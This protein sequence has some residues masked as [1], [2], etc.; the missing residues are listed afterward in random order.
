MRDSET[1]GFELHRFSN[2]LLRY[3]DLLLQK[4][5]GFGYSHF[6][7]MVAL[8]A[9]PDCMQASVAHFL[10]QTEASISRQLKLMIKE[11]LAESRQNPTNRREH[12]IHLTSKGEQQ[13]QEAQSY[14]EAEHSP[15]FNR[16]SDHEQQAFMELAATVRMGLMDR[17]AQL[18][19]DN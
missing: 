6:K 2:V 16:L 7:I 19:A 5:F 10:G 3:A 17:L 15:I 9:R 12:V 8:H 11:G 1:L 4:R 18:K 13:L 14:L